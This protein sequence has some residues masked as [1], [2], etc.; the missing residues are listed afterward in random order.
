MENV[1]GYI[2]IYLLEFFFS[3]F[4]VVGS[5][6][7]H[8]RRVISH[9]SWYIVISL[10]KLLESGKNHKSPAFTRY[11]T[12]KSLISKRPIARVT[13]LY[14]G[15][16]SSIFVVNISHVGKVVYALYSLIDLASETYSFIE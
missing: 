10:F 3:S 15:S 11:H 14:I 8:V 4:V 2:W 13:L 12:F 7:F 5:R 9:F 16:E 6:D 1:V